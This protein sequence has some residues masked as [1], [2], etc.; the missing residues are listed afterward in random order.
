M[1]H[2]V[3]L[4]KAEPGH[5]QQFLTAPCLVKPSTA[6]P[7]SAGTP[8]PDSNGRHPKRWRREPCRALPRRTPPY[9]AWPDQTMPRPALPA[10]AGTPLADL[11]SLHACRE[12]ENPA[13]PDRA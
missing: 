12:G 7:A 3:A 1:P 5:A 4:C 10:F 11:N 2:H 9:P 13:S 8:L 6:L